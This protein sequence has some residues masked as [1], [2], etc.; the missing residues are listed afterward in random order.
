MMN[1][2]MPPMMALT[3]STSS[4]PAARTRTIMITEPTQMGR[5]NCWLRLEPAPANMTKPVLNR[6]IITA[7]SRTLDM[8][9][10][11]MRSKTAVCSSAR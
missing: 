5:P 4:M 6:V 11:E 3:L 2:V 8:I 1:G 7:M 9:G 10:E